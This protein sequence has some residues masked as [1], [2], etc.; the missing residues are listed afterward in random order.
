MRLIKFVFSRF[1]ICVT[2]IAALFAA[3]IFLCFYI[4]S[5]LP[6]AA[7]IA[8]SYLLS[9]IAALH[10]LSSDGPS[11]F[12]CGW[13]ILIVALPV[14]GAVLY[15]L[16]FAERSNKVK[17]PV[18]LP[19]SSCTSFTYFSDGTTFL[20]GLVSRISAAKKQVLL[21][22]YII[23]KGHIWG[24]TFR[25]LK[26]ALARGVE[27]KIVYDGWG[28]AL[29]APKK[30]FKELK[31]AGAQIKVFNRLTPLPVSRL[32]FRDHRKIAVIDGDEVF[33]GGVN[34][35]D[36]YANLSSPHG[37][38]KDGGALFFGDIARVYTR[39]FLS[40][41]NGENIN[42]GG[43]MPRATGKYELIPVADGPENAGSA[44]ED[45]L[46]SALYSARER[47]YIFTPYLCVG[48]KLHDALIFAVRRGADVKLLIPAVPDKKLTYAVTRSYCERL[49]GEGVKVYTYTPGF[50]HFK[51]AVCDDK[52]LLGSYNLDFRSMRL[53]YEC[54]VIGG[55][56]LADEMA[57]DFKSCLALSS[58]FTA[59]KR[60]AAGRLARSALRLFAPLV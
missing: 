17:K 45:A 1:F 2:V 8:V 47:A 55:A 60:R 50:M 39:I 24:A 4:H 54:A 22:F 42:W 51:G 56:E 3:I 44:C 38:W 20:D 48:D 53:N 58:V 36:E 23:S 13:M 7:A 19:A 29:R 11:E 21:E 14:S 43:D 10:L 26:G 35:A 12:K 34:I 28:S 33:L 6:A 5:L 41:F 59:K 37:Y 52:A 16:Y 18:A 46:A 25:E 32:N 9:L 49:V 27:V 31:K 30:D 57:D 15:F 40:Q